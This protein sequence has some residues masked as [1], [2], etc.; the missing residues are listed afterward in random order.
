M[1][2]SVI[3][4]VVKVTAARIRYEHIAASRRRATAER[5]AG[6]LGELE[7]LALQLPAVQ[8]PD[9]P[10]RAEVVVLR[11]AI[12][13]LSMPQE[14]RHRARHDHESRDGDHRTDNGRALR[15][16]Q[17]GQQ[18]DQPHAHH[19]A[20]RHPSSLPSIE[21]TGPREPDRQASAETDPGR[22]VIRLQ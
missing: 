20:G 4:S 19:R 18:H 9:D 1:V 17:T 8:S 22:L 21:L 10:D 12:T 14:Q 15:E 6:L 5:R 16:H 2:I 13:V 3:N 7:L 11:A